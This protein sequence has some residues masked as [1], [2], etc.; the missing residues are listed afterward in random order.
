MRHGLDPAPGPSGGGAET[1]RLGG[2]GDPGR[3]GA[4]V[5]TVRHLTKSY[6]GRTGP[7][8]A[9]DRLDPE[10]RAGE[11]GALLGPNGAGKTTL[12]RQVAGHLVPSSGSIEIAGIDV[13]RPPIPAKRFLSVI[14]QECEPRGDLTV[15]E[16]LRGSPS[17]RPPS[18]P[19]T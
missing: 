12:L 19:A 11:I 4:P 3:T 7:R 2:I 1:E 10:V 8:L 6:R 5:L 13:V 14:P 18:W 16:H 15:E 9:N 17:P